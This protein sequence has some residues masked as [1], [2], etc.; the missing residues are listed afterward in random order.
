[1]LQGQVEALDR[2]IDRQLRLVADLGHAVAL[3]TTIPGVG[4]ITAVTLLGEAGD[5]RAFRRGRQLAAFVGVSPRRYDS[6]SSVRGRTRMCRI[7]GAHARTV[8]YMAAVA[9]SRTRHASRGLL[10]ASGGPGEAQEIRPRRPHEETGPRHAGRPDPGRTLFPPASLTPCYSCTAEPTSTDTARDKAPRGRKGC[11]AVWR[12]NPCALGPC[13]AR[14]II[15][16]RRKSFR[17]PCF[18]THHIIRQE[19]TV[20]SQKQEVTCQNRR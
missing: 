14:A 13:R 11:A 2:A 20:P 15:C 18:Q 8:L 19:F 16:P 3:L 17:Y 10:P 1:V 9:A 7:G 12:C 4:R 5:L 6:G